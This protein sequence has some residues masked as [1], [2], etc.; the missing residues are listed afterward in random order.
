MVYLTSAIL[1]VCDHYARV[2]K[3]TGEAQTEWLNCR[4]EQLQKDAQVWLLYRLSSAGLTLIQYSSDCAEWDEK[5][6]SL[7]EKELA[8][9]RDQRYKEYYI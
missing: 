6:G 4:K 5:R 9:A 8:D 1:D 3:E 7:R 2:Q